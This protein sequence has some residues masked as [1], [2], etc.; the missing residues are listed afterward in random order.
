[1]FIG[2]GARTWD[3]L[4][5]QKAKMMADTGVDPRTIWKETGTWKGPDGKWRQEIPDNVPKIT[6][7]V[8]YG[9][10]ANQRFTGPIKQAL[11][12][13]DLFRAYPDTSDISSGFYAWSKPEGSYDK[14]T[15][16]IT[17]GGPGTTSQKSAAVHELQHAIQQREGF[18]RGGSSQE[19]ISDIEALSS[20]NRMGFSEMDD[21]QKIMLADLRKKYGS[22][23]TPQQAYQNL[24]GEAEARA[25]QARM[26]MTA[27]QRRATFPEESYDVPLNELI[28]RGASD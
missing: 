8:F 19:F 10:K 25:T 22:I 15:D 18:A 2:K 14:F 23:K 11:P 24:A 20:L 6:D 5:A 21:F 12:H 27:E 17:A 1:M 7:D 16:S 26:N 4:A 3:A 13:E 9:I 28:I